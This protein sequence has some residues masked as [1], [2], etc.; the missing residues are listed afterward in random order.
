MKYDI[1]TLKW[2]VLLSHFVWKNLDA[3]FFARM[4]FL[5]E[6]DDNGRGWNMKKLSSSAN[7][8]IC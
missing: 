2:K 6:W 4:I 3:Y 7:K 1:L 8:S 5:E